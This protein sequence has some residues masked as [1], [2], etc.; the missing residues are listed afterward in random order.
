MIDAVQGRLYLPGSVGTEV[1]GTK[2]TL[3]DV[4]EDGVGEIC[5]NAR[6]VVMGYHKYSC[7]YLSAHTC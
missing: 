2:S 1:Y 7:S 6:T 5:A 4:G 3:L